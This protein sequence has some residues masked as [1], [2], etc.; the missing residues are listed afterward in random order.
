MLENDKDPLRH[1][2]PAIIKI[3]PI[4]QTGQLVNNHIFRFLGDF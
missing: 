2:N 4:L 3:W 1:S